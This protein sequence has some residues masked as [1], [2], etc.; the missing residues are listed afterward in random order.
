MMIVTADVAKSSQKLGVG[1]V[2]GVVIGGAVLMV[3]IIL[4]VCLFLCRRKSKA[5]NGLLSHAD[6]FNT[7]KEGT[8][9]A[10][11]PLGWKFCNSLAQLSSQRA[12]IP[13][14]V[15]LEQC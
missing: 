7:G 12:A 1:A 5:S 15:I 14:D 3:G 6:F 2:I 10:F 4:L 13:F 8:P 9:Q 11:G